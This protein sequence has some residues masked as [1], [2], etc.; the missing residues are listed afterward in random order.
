MLRF[1]QTSIVEI[2]DQ[3]GCMQDGTQLWDSRKENSDTYEF[4]VP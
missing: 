4:R 1:L 2:K 3:L